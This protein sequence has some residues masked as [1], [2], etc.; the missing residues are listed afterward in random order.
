MP[1]EDRKISAVI[2]KVILGLFFLGLAV[3]LLLELQW[4]RQ[5][6]LVLKGSA[7][8]LLILAGIL[9]LAIAKE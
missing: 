8:A 2:L 7:P 4:W 6:W 5:T 3:Y 1:R 9:T